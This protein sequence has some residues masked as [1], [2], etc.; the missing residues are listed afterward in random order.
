[1]R[2]I[3]RERID[4]A[5]DDNHLVGKWLKESRPIGDIMYKELMNVD[6]LE[7]ARELKTPLLVI[8][9]KYDVDSPWKILKENIEHYGG[10]YTFFLLENSHHLVYIDE[11][12]RFVELLKTFLL[13]ED[14]GDSN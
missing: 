9:G 1:M 6:L 14:N 10:E 7:N 4:N 12:D 3:S 8:A 2:N 11:E 13:N 5:I